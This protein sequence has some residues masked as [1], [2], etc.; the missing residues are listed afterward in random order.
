MVLSSRRPR[1]AR[2]EIIPM[3]DV[4]FFLLVFFMMASLAMT[5][6]EGLPVSLPHSASSERMKAE[7][8]AITV[9]R[10]GQLFLNREPVTLSKLSERLRPML[11]KNRELAVVINADRDVTH[12]R[13]V[14]TLD[15]LRQTGAHRVAI[16]VVPDATRGR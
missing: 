15:A 5:L 8:A 12:A 6:Y 11:A 9:N 7:T 3:I 2:I 1:K 16:A 4:V 10:E 14:D 13:V